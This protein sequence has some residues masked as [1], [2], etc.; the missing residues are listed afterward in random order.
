MKAVTFHELNA[1]CKRLGCFLTLDHD[2]QCYRAS[3]PDGKR[4][5]SGLHELI[6]V[7]GDGFIG[8][9]ATKAEAREDLSYRLRGYAAL[10]SCDDLCD[11]SCP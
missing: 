11:G 4:F 8:N 10:E 3:A 6:A 5:E 9:G 2:C 1:E 7:F